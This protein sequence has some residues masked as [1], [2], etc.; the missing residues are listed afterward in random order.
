VPIILDLIDRLHF[1]ENRMRA[2]GRRPIRL[3]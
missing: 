2:A 3:S 1:L